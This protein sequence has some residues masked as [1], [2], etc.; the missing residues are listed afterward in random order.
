MLM[1]HF[2]KLWSAAIVAVLGLGSAEATTVENY[3]YDFNNQIDTSQPLFKVASNWGHTDSPYQDDYGSVYYMSYSYKPTGG[4][5]GSGALYAGKQQAGDSWDYGVVCDCLVTPIVSG[6]ITLKV[7]KNDS[8][9][10]IKL[11]ATTASGKNITGNALV[12]ETASGSVLNSNDYV[13]ITYNV[14]E[15]QRIAINAQYCYLDDFTAEV[16]EIQDEPDMKIMTAV[17]NQ[18]T[19]VIKWN[20]AQD[21]TVT[22]KYAVTVQ[23]V[24]NVT[25]TAN[26][27]SNYSISIVYGTYNTVLSTTPV[28]FT[29]EPGETSEEFD[30]TAVI[31]AD[32][33][34]NI[35]PYSSSS[36][37]MNLLNNLNGAKTT[38]AGSQ[39]VKYE[40]KF[41]FKVKDRGA[42]LSTAYTVPFGI[43]EEAKS[44]TFQLLNEGNAPLTIK[45]FTL[46]EGYLCDAEIPEG[47]FILEPGTE[48]AM[49]ITLTRPAVPG[50]YHGNVV[51]VYV[52]A[53]GEE[54]TYSL[55]LGG[56]TL[57]EGQWGADFNNS[58]SSIKFGDGTIAQAG[59][60]NDKTYMGAFDLYDQWVICSE[61]NYYQTE[62]NLYITP[63]M[64]A[65]PGDELYFEAGKN[66]TS[67][68]DTYGLKVYMSADRKNWGEPIMTILR[69][70][71]ENYLF[72]PYTYTATESGDCYLAFEVYGMKLDN[73][74]GFQ[75]ADVPYDFEVSLFSVPERTKSGN[76]ITATMNVLKTATAQ[77]DEYTVKLY[78]DDVETASV[79]T[80]NMIYDAKGSKDFTAKVT[81]SPEVT[82]TYAFRMD[83]EFTDGTVISSGTKM[84]TV[85]FEPEFGFY[86]KGDHGSAYYHDSLTT[87]IAF[88]KINT[89]G[90]V[91]NF[92]FYNWGSAPLSITGFTVPEGYSVS[93]TEATV[94]PLE[95]QDVD[96][97][98]TAEEPGEYS[99]D[100]EVS[101]IDGEGNPATYTLPISGTMLDPTKWYVTFDNGTTNGA[102]PAGSLHQTNAT[103][104]NVGDYSN[105]NMALHS[106]ST[107]TAANR[108]FIS[109]KVHS[110]GEN[111]QMDL[112][113]Y[114]SSYTEGGVQIYVSA[115]R[116]GLID[117]PAENATLIA[118]FRG[119]EVEEEYLLTT[120]LTTTNIAIPEGDWY[121]GIAPYSRA[122]V[123]NI[124]G[125]TV[126]PVEG[127]DVVSGGARIP[128]TT[129]QNVLV[130]AVFK[131]YNVGLEAIAADA[132]TVTAY[133]DGHAIPT[134]TS[135]AIPVVTTLETPT[136][137]AAPFRY[138]KV[139][140]FPVYLVFESGDLRIETE[141]VDVEFLPEMLNSE[142]QIGEVN[143]NA[144]E[145]PVN[146]YYKLSES[147]L[148][149]TSELLGL[150]DGDV[151]T[152]FAFRG[153]N[154]VDGKVTKLT[155]YS[156]LVDD[157]T[158]T[159]PTTPT[160]Y[161]DG[162]ALQRNDTEDQPILK[163]GV[164]G[165][166]PIY[167]ELTVVEL[168]H[169]ITYEAGKALKLVFHN[170][171]PS[172]ISSSSCRTAVTDIR[173]LAYS[174]ASD[175]SLDNA[176]WTDKALPV[177]YL[178]LSAESAQMHGIVSDR[179]GNAVSGAVV[180]LTSNDGDNV[181][182]ETTADENGAYSV[183]VIQA[184]REYDAV[185]SAENMG[186]F[187]DG[188]TVS[189]SIEKNYTLRPIFRISETA[190]HTGGAEA[191][192]VYH[193]SRYNEGYNAVTLPVSLDAEEI[194][195]IF[196]EATVLQFAGEEVSGSHATAQFAQTTEMQAGVPY[197]VYLHGEQPEAIM[198]RTKDVAE[199]LTATAGTALTFTPTSAPTD[200]APGMFVLDDVNFVPASQLVAPATDGEIASLPAY[201]AFIQ[202]GEAIQSV[203]FTND[204]ALPVA[205][206]T[207]GEQQGDDVVYDLGGL[208]VKNPKK[209]LYIVNGKAYILK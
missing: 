159:K 182:Y 13:E 127:L 207:V 3:T 167:D 98:F 51:I 140:N 184:S 83:M 4:V 115:T 146:Y 65:E 160:Y 145:V 143:T 152:R 188:I 124:Y 202:A 45:S 134:A 49:D 150:N 17:P 128:Q 28:P 130:P 120:T 147:V 91:K 99:G 105:P 174:K 55:P 208:R 47:E 27:T 97:T 20:Q 204:A 185:V 81:L 46:P 61:S 133:V 144:Y 80:V 189:E 103:L 39:V 175:S 190:T 141:P 110:A 54:K 112:S 148:L 165:G 198:F 92:E 177:L 129:M 88:G 209:G 59:V 94:N 19:G 70:D 166:S 179:E 69:S 161:A 101:Y 193:D 75:K 102:W 137:I 86:K 15:P 142:K 21:G 40:P 123:D 168:A 96:I 53:A 196:G 84:A 12:N 171:Q 173:N 6:Q 57:Q 79:E 155:C 172:Y 106:T 72:S 181:Q 186:E 178:G 18:T 132:Y 126:L 113:V 203:G 90:T 37:A 191:S 43:S 122:R 31:P 11:Y 89:P 164:N 138:P 154:T 125:L 66:G 38:R 117:N 62:K 48:S 121:I 34:S 78:V 197:L 35:W 119:K 36:I 151:I 95:S 114:N 56:I 68:A 33:I 24:G 1:K 176:T 32:Q 82:T 76:Q 64:H 9:S 169:P 162:M 8:S 200:L 10:F 5:D 205:V 2:T 157:Q 42:T 93:L 87:P 60:T 136:E 192:I 111:I 58:L 63:R 139:G 107:I 71:L 67:I 29:L 170:E 104:T 195:A 7:K 109:P 25:L 30:V 85:T 74:A 118:D 153:Y 108:M 135:Q 206:E 22:I 180:L 158:L 52:D 149:Y 26:E 77:S 156:Q 14:E 41:N 199:E 44:W 163:V 183:D 100:I 116:E 50:R 131:I 73:I 16:A 187:E 201:S 194:A 23:N